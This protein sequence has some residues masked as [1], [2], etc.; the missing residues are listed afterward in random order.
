MLLSLDLISNPTHWS[1]IQLK[2]SQRIW[3]N[4]LIR[5]L[6]YYV[7]RRPLQQRKHDIPGLSQTILSQTNVPERFSNLLPFASVTSLNS[8]FSYSLLN[9]SASFQ[10]I[11][12]LIKMR[13]VVYVL[14]TVLFHT[15]LDITLTTTLR[16]RC[17]YDSFSKT[18][19][20]RRVKQLIQIT[21]P[22]S[23]RAEVKLRPS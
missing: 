16:D 3:W 7:S 14:G 22:V 1:W 23:I 2:P 10:V 11:I 21:Q 18:K 5:F 13:W 6:N 15:L 17:N 20:Q 4:T 19:R 12:I 8:H 9:F